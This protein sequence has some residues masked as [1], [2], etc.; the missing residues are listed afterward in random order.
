MRINLRAYGGG[1]AALTDNWLLVDVLS[2][3]RPI[4]VEVRSTVARSKS[5]TEILTGIA[6]DGCRRDDSRGGALWHESCELALEPLCYTSAPAL[7]D[8]LGRRIG[9]DILFAFLQPIED[10]PRRGLGGR[11]RYLEAPVHI[12]VDRA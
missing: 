3:H 12:S 9:E 6:S 11:L 1:D 4:K 8:G 5:L 7:R 2:D 10:A